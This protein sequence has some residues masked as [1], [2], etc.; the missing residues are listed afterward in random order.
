MW[1]LSK[2]VK[3]FTL[4][5]SP[6]PAFYLKAL[7]PIKWHR[8]EDI[9]G[10]CLTWQPKFQT[11]QQTKYLIFWNQMCSFYS[12]ICGFKFCF[13]V[14]QKYWVKHESMVSFRGGSPTSI[15]HFFLP[16]AH[17]APYL[18]N[19][20]V[21]DHNFWYTCKTICWSIFFLFFKN[22]WFFGLLGC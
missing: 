18:R 5:P 13:K 22:F 7:P 19:H 2:I 12:Y 15:C 16:F 9:G 20:T 4:P 3:L 11:I 1:K 10:Q 8:I 14:D 21:S 17:H 6:H